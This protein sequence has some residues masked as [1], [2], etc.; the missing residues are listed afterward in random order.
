MTT[1]TTVGY[2]DISG[3]NTTERI[4]CIFLHLI[5]V[6]SYSIAAGSLTS[7]LQNYDEM[8]QQTQEKIHV[9]NRLYKENNLPNDIYYTL[10]N[11]IQNYSLHSSQD[12]I[13]EFLDDLPFRLKLRTILYIYKDLYSQIPF[14]NKQIDNFI[15]WIFP[16]LNQMFIPMDQYIYYETDQIVEIYFQ[17]SGYSAFVLPFKQNIVYIDIMNGDHFGEIDFF[18][19]AKE[20]EMTIAEMMDNLNCM[21]F[22][23]VRQFT[24]QAIRDSNYLTMSITNIQRMHKQFSSQFKEL[25]KNAKRTLFRALEQKAKAIRKIDDRHQVFTLVDYARSNQY[26][27]NQVLSEMEKESLKKSKAKLDGKAK[28]GPQDQG[29]VQ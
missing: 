6:I 23:L 9:L 13:K 15:A 18:I 10:L 20:Q 3:Q 22:N 7:I 14:L 25:F 1:L 24:I 19:S 16:L 2:G 12:E 26:V 28:G 29:S 21:K 4:I 11:Q 8:N 17:T 5:G 27:R